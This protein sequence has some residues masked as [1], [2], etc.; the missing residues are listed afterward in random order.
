MDSFNPFTP[1]D[2]IDHLYRAARPNRPLFSISCSLLP[3]LYYH[4]HRIH[5]RRPDINHS[6]IRRKL[7]FISH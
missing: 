7:N 1:L 4:L 2:L 6:K 3:A 5:I